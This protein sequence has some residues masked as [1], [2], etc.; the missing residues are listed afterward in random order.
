M[1]KSTKLPEHQR[2]KAKKCPG[3]GKKAFRQNLLEKGIWKCEK[4]DYVNIKVTPGHVTFK[5]YGKD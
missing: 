1:K 3:C 2:S 4:C 5:I